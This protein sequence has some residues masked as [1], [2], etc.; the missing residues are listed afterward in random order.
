MDIFNYFMELYEWFSD[1]LCDVRGIFLVLL[2][3]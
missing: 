2:V 1:N 3:L